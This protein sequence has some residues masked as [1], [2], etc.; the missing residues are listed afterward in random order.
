[1]FFWLMELNLVSLKGSAVNVI[2]FGG[3]L[4]VQYTFGQSF[5]LCQCQTHLFP[6]P[7]QSGP[8]R[9]ILLSPAP[10][11]SLES[12]LV[13]LFPGL[14]L[15]CRPKLAKSGPVWIFLCSLTLPFVSRRCVWASLSPLKLPYMSQ[16]LC[17]FACLVY[18]T[19][20]LCCRYCVHLSQ[21]HSLR[22]AGEGGTCV[23]LSCLTGPALY[24][25]GLV[26]SFGSPVLLSML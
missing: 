20:P 26:C 4:S 7:F 13:L 19:H 17:A 21:A 25:A 24:V 14:A 3:C 10:Y 16:G 6:Q 5:W 9:I 12:S 15:D 18:W 11:L 23:H 1:M 22:G 8:L 2:R